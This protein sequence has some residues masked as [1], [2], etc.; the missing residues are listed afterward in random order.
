MV[1]YN[2]PR[3]RRAARPH[4]GDGVCARRVG[5]GVARR[6]GPGPHPGAAPRARAPRR[7]RP[8][9]AASLG[10]VNTLIGSIDTSRYARSISF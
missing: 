1:R 4:L 7:H 5:A 6:G 9:R 10:L 2:A 3:A 8:R